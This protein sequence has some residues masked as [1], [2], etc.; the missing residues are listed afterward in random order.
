MKQIYKKRNFKYWTAKKLNKYSMQIWMG[1]IIL[2]SL[3]TL[4]ALAR[5]YTDSLPKADPRVSMIPQVQASEV[6]LRKESTRAWRLY[7]KIRWNESNNG[8][9]GL[10]VTCKGKGEINEIGWLPYKGFCFKSDWE[11][12]LTAMQYIEKKLNNGWTEDSVLC[13]WNTGK[14]L[15]TC[16]Y[17]RGD[18]K[19]AN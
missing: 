7:Q 3:F 5:H 1:I 16:P 13:Y 9:R 17:S 15:S 11:Q 8:T 2:M 19:N 10:A 12:E 6:E 18:L 14:V 4:W